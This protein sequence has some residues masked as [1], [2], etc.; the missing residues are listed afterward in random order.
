MIARCWV[1]GS[2][3]IAI[4]LSALDVGCYWRQLQ[5]RL[6]HKCCASSSPCANWLPTRPSPPCPMPAGL[7]KQPVAASC[8]RRR[9]AIL[10]TTHTRSSKPALPSS[11]VVAAP[12]SA[13]LPPCVQRWMRH[14]PVQSHC[15]LY[16]LYMVNSK[17]PLLPI[18]RPAW[19]G[20]WQRR[21]C[22][23]RRNA[24]TQRHRRAE[25]AG[26]CANAQG[27][28]CE[29][30]R[31][32]RCRWHGCVWARGRRHTSSKGNWPGDDP[33]FSDTWPEL[34]AC[35]VRLVGGP[36]VGNCNLF[37]TMGDPAR[38]GDYPEAMDSYDIVPTGLIELISQQ[39]DR[40]L[41][42]A[43]AQLDQLT[44]LSSAAH[45]RSTRRSRSMKPGCWQK[46]R[47]GADFALTQPVFDAQQARDFI[48]LYEAEYGPLTLPL[49]AGIMPLFNSR[50]ALF[51]TMK[52]RESLFL[53]CTGSGWIRRQT[54]RRRAWRLRQRS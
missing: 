50:N 23:Y 19:R 11:A 37:V 1:L 20:R 4:K 54:R 6:R 28:R 8:I 25:N 13:I 7:N 14:R 29:F 10:P 24:S 18:R 46:I 34:V 12:I 9:H 53:R 2:A 16:A 39:F 31:C 32:R 47:S 33:A 26:R 41:D 5:R 15:P 51:C 17:I 45:Y 22:R 38:I 43:G 27:S 40:G 30:P 44:N 48:A 21:I 35:A 52:C 42:K 3:E 36:C 49:I